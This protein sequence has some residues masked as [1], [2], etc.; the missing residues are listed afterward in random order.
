MTQN[1]EFETAILD[2]IRNLAD[3]AESTYHE[4][5][6][7]GSPPIATAYDE[8]RWS[9]IRE[10]LDAVTAELSRWRAPK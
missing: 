9:G 6:S 1:A 3:Q 10:A 4:N 8:G 7:A 5:R 2:A